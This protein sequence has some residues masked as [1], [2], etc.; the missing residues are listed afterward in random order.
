M[1]Y[2]PLSLIISVLGETLARHAE[3]RTSLAA[4]DP[5]ARPA[6]AGHALAEL[7]ERALAR[8]GT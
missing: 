2:K 8:A 6:A 1:L 4:G 7:C 3:R 5:L